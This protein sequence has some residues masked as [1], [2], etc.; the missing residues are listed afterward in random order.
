[1]SRVV[2]IETICVGHPDFRYQEFIALTNSSEKSIHLSGWKVV[3]TEIPSGRELHSYVF[4]FPRTGS[5]DPREKLFLASG[6]GNYRFRKPGEDPK[7]PI[8][9]WVIFTGSP[10]HICSVPHLKVTLYDA[11]GTEIDHRYSHQGRDEPNIRP[12]IVIGHGRDSA[13][14]EVKDYLHDQLG[15]SVDAFEMEPH[16][17]ETIPQIIASLGA[18]SNM[19]ILVLSGED[20]TDA[21]TFRARQNVIHEL[22]KFQ[23]KFGNKRTII[24]VEKDVEVPSN[25][26]GLIRLDY[27]RGHIDVTF[28]S[29]MAT[30]R[31]EFKLW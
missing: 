6:T 31:K 22:G 12:S 27:K 13:W 25:I 18:D 16:T 29:I 4:D 10:K 30:I 26:S 23:E 21:G 9:H 14:R 3:W 2:A 17:S 1:M 20:K 28:G 8:A 19:A 11:T 5:F 15:F 7:C 24:L